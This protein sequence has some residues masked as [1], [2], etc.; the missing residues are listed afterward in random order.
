M[1][2]LSWKQISLD[3]KSEL[4]EKTETFFPW[5]DKFVSIIYLWDNSA[6]KTYVG[7]KKKYGEDIGLHVEVFGQENDKK[8]Q[9]ND[10]LDIYKNQEYDIVPKILELIAV[11]NY[12]SDCVGIIVQLPLPEPFAQYKNEILSSISPTKDI[13][14]LWWIINGLSEMWLVDFIP[15]TPKSVLHLLKHYKL[16]DVDGKT[17]A[18]LG[19]SNLVGKP[20]AVELMKMGAT[21]YSTNA[22]ND[23]KLIQENCRK[24]DYIISCTGKIHLVDENY[25]WEKNNQIIID[26]GYGYKDGK[27]VGDVQLD[28]IADMVA[29]YTPVPGGIGPL[30]VACLFDN[31]FELQSY[32]DILKPF[33]L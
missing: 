20:L 26:V 5:W 6:S 25:I 21:I 33:K 28:K 18:I 15:A 32:K 17:V 11:M 22:S 4:K 1:T 29:S 30:T 3:L 2:V 31:V 16:D 24:A 19:Q 23:Q 27:P 9:W 8:C 13:D 7:L 14:G 10:G 12:D